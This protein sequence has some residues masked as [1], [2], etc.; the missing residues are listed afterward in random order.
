M[1]WPGWCL[2][3][4][5]TELKAQVATLAAGGSQKAVVCQT[6]GL[7]EV[8]VSYS[9]PAVTSRGGQDRK[10]EIWGRL[11][12]FG[13]NQERWLEK[14]GEPTSPKPWRAGANENTVIE[15]SHDVLIEGVAVPAGKYGLFFIP[16]EH[17]WELILSKDAENWGHYSYRDDR[18]A[19]RVGITPEK[20]EYRE[21]LTYEFRE[22]KTDRSTLTLAWEELSVP[23]RI[24][25][26]NLH[27]IY[28]NQIKSDLQSRKMLY[29]YNW[30]EAAKYCLENNL[31][32][33]LGLEWIEKAIRQTWIGAANFSTLKTKA[34]LLFA[35]DR[36]NEG[37][38]V[39]Q[40]AIKYTGGVF[41]LHNYGRELLQ[42]DK[43]EEAFAVFETNASKHPGYWVTH[44]GLAR[45]YGARRDFK[46]ALK[47][48]YSARKKIPQTEAP[49]CHAS[50]AVLI[51]QLEKRQTP[52]I[53]L[54]NGLTQG[55]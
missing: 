14:D 1:V 43:L 49:V 21:W 30:H 19:L 44:V 45:A 26:P 18:D 32:L 5:S 35:L 17:E 48:A 38:S 47:H 29:W 11:V 28:I 10:G 9:S 40:F 4:L 12:P 50:L 2:T 41:E 15:I 7:V 23:I 3:F 42:K 53:Y 55:F 39:M 27:E 31:E 6:M 25:V 54:A 33:E 24:T 8:C 36:K 34:E 22:R 20:S 46:A 13:W 37:D 51:D 52:Q 16:G